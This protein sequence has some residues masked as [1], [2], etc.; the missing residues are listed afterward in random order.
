M[1][2]LIIIGILAAHLGLLIAAVVLGR[3]KDRPLDGTT[4]L[5]CLLIPLFGPICG[6]EMV[7]SREPDASLL[8]EMIMSDQKLRRSY[9]A[10]E[11]EAS[12]TTPMEEAFI[13]NEPQVRRKMMMKLLLQIISMPHFFIKSESIK[14][15][16]IFVDD[17]NDYRH[18]PIYLP[19]LL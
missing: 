12:T 16:I 10:P 7:F 1:R 3:G 18:L 9:I 19:R 8:K 2:N 17:E 13:I 4:V 6:L 14:N 11:A 5:F 15:N